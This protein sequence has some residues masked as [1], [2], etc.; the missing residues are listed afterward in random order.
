LSLSVTS[1]SHSKRA[2]FESFPQLDSQGST[3]VHTAAPFYDNPP[4]LSDNEGIYGNVP[5]ELISRGNMSQVGTS[6]EK[7]QYAGAPYA[8]FWDAKKTYK[9]CVND[10]DV[11][12][13]VFA[14]PAEEQ[15]AESPEQRLGT[16]KERL[17]KL[18]SALYRKQPSAVVGIQH[19]HDPRVIYEAAFGPHP[20]LGPDRCVPRPK[21]M[22]KYDPRVVSI[23]A[24]EDAQKHIAKEST[25]F[26]SFSFKGVGQNI[27]RRLAKPEPDY[28]PQ[29]LGLADQAH[30][31]PNIYSILPKDRVGSINNWV[32]TLVADIPVDERQENFIALTTAELIAIGGADIDGI[33]IVKKYY[34]PQ[35]TPAA[36]SHR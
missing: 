19:M 18:V 9:A 5:V 29:M 12:L 20:A 10:K 8:N 35:S 34:A 4:N 16:V 24:A 17:S 2:V 32:E 22:P 1:S 3:L 25:G 21:S 23:F 27:S 6:L 14:G 11:T 7:M 30:P 31:Y 33:E 28:R 36:G 15:D 26:R 13:D